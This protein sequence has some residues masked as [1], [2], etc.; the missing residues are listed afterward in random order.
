MTLVQ[1]T[2]P[3]CHHSL[4]TPFFDGGRK[5]LATLGWPKTEAEAQA[6]PRYP[7]DYVQ[8]P[9]CSHIWNRSFSYDAIPYE[10][11]PNRMFNSGATW[12]EYLSE[13][14][15][16]L[17]PVLAD[18][19][20]IIDIGCGEG[21]FVRSL[22]ELGDGRGRYIGFDPNVTEESGQGIEF[23]ARY[24]EPLVDFE[25]FR[26]NL[27]AMRHVLEHLTD[28]AVF[29]EKLAWAATGLDTP[30]YFFA[31][32]PCVD[33]A[34]ETDRLVDFFY[35]HPSQF[36][37]RSFTELMKRGGELIEIS[38]GYNGEVINGLVRLG[39]P[40][41]R[42]D[43]VA[44]AE[45]FFNRSNGNRES[46]AEQLRALRASG[47]SIAVWGGTGK[48]A[49]FIQQYGLSASDFPLVVDSDPDKEGTFVPGSGQ[50]IRFRDHLK[51]APV[52]V[53]IIPTQWRARDIVAEIEREGIA[54]AQVLVEHNGQL[55]DYREG[56]HP[57]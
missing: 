47:R 14:Q 18:A 50:R 5:T 9:E 39:V 55:V 56:S 35:E 54:V 46:F 4:A 34:V 23:H 52:D 19:P 10:E 45:G 42:V 30:V 33:R 40:R 7:L 12:R 32:T 43:Q 11:N 57:Y 28:P 31:E 26:P 15:E 6:M 17:Q 53:V 41:A 13:V 8:C 20:T 29:L 16:R 24:F 21:H 48:A 3:V 51:S 27:L 49:N 38:H 44:H 22:S 37:T 36:T 25:T 2:C 1:A